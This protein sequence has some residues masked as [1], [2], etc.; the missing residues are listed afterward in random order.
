VIALQDVRRQWGPFSLRVTLSAEA[1]QY[2]VI[3]GPSGCGKSLLLG[4]VAGLYLPR[5][6]RV[7]LDGRD[8]T[9]APT[10]ERG[11]GFVFQRSALFPHLSVR[12]NIAFGLRSR[13]WTR[14]DR[15]ARVDEL[16]TTLGLQEVLERPVP[17]LSGGE[18]Q[19]VAIA[20]ALAPRP[21]VLLLDEPLSLVDHNARLELQEELRRIH[22]ELGITALHV[23]HNREEART[24][25]RRCAV[26]LGGRIVQEG[27]TEEVFE[28]PRCLFVARF[29][30]LRGGPLP[31]GPGCDESCLLGSGICD[32][33]YQ[34]SA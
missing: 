11:L 13:R 5:S 6:G 7:L 15:R 30:G 2:L 1:G 8:V 22:A 28:R 18:S 20:R 16:V 25:G 12:A 26:M 29:L 21:P 9:D 19:K 34:E 14:A 24:L 23:T 31:E 27:T 33:P 10:E 17:A 32:M 4:T 3:L